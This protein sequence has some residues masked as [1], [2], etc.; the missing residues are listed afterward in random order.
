VKHQADASPIASNNLNILIMIQIKMVLKAK[1]WL[2][3]NH[4]PA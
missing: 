1:D 3:F 4:L 2:I